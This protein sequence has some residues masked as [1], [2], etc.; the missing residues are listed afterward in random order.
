MNRIFTAVYLLSVPY[1]YESGFWQPYIYRAFAT[2]INWILKA[3]YVYW[4][5]L[6]IFSKPQI[7]WDLQIGLKKVILNTVY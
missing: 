3:V 5:L 7:N 1:R 4:E 6:I 2:G